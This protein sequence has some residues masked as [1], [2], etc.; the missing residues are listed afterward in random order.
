[1]QVNNKQSFGCKWGEYTLF[2]LTNSN[3]IHVDITDLGASLVNFYVPEKGGRRI[4]IVLGY[5]T[6]K[7]YLEGDAFIGGVV[8]PWANRINGGA[9]R[10]DGNT[11][12]LEQNE[13]ANHLHG[14]S[15][16]LHKKHWEVETVT[17]QKITLKTRIK[18]GE[19]GFPA[20]ISIYV[21]YQ[22][23]NDNALNIHY[24]AQSD[25]T[26]PI[27]LTQHAYFNLS[28]GE[29]NILDHMI[30]ID[31]ETYLA[32][33]DQFI[34]SRKCAVAGTA[35]DF[36]Q[37]M[38]IG[39]YIHLDDEQLL[40]AGG[41]DHCW[42]LNGRGLRPIAQVYAKKTGITLNIATDQV[43]VQFYSG[44]SLQDIDGRNGAIYQK[45]DGLCLETQCY[46]DQVNMTEPAECILKL[47]ELYRHTT[48]YQVITD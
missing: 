24:K 48:V 4:N 33:D 16:G 35:M 12:Q 23:T 46:P 8:G 38:R 32:I 41:Y 29:E 43:G 22:L 36:R 19:A 30:H 42:C 26:T 34:P 1:M 5:D 9:F 21:T 37:P 39:S 27:N 13:G 20:N 28:G 2:S 3:L 10:L 11:V 18:Q 7:A 40:I 6:A 25:G 15:A 44:N 17:R 31:A 47:G 45:Y 14:A